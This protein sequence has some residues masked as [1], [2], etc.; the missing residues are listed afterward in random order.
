M[1][2]T[3][4][5]QHVV[6]PS[7]ELVSQ[8]RCGVIWITVVVRVPYGRFTDSYQ[9]CVN[10]TQDV[11]TKMRLRKATAKKRIASSKRSLK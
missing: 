1:E 5:C 11:N 2:R 8:S 3:P 4:Q 6:S 10:S 7:L 9:V